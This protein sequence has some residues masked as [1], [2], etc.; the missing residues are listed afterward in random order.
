MDCQWVIF[1]TQL[2]RIRLETAALHNC[3]MDDS[4]VLTETH[5][6]PDNQA[7][8]QPDSQLA[9][10]QSTSQ[11]LAPEPPA[12][13]HLSPATKL[14][15]VLSSQQSQHPIPNHQSPVTNQLPP[16]EL[17]HRASQPASLKLHH[18]PQPANMA[19]GPGAGDWWLG[20]GDWGLGTAGWSFVAGDWWL[21]TGGWGLVAGDWRL[22]AGDWKP[23]VQIWKPLDSN[24]IDN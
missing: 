18:H 17:V 13:S 20:T 10:F 15:P 22:V 19:W 12:T 2:T 11:A 24:P 9:H 1:G 4:Q 6:Q 23:M 5:S 14:Q 3:A 8:K 7:S 21:E 16:A